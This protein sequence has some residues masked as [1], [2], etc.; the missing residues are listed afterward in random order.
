M[1]VVSCVAEWEVGHGGRSQDMEVEIREEAVSSKADSTPLLASNTSA[2]PVAGK[3][4][5]EYST[6]SCKVEN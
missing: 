1:L 3:L 6:M 4:N 2:Y 5:G